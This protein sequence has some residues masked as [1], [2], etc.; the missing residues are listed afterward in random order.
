[1]ETSRKR[2]SDPNATTSPRGL[3]LEEPPG[4]LAMLRDF[5]PGSMLPRPPAKVCCG[6]LEIDRIE[7][8]AVL[9]GRALRLTGREFA[10]LLCLA[11]HGNRVV[12]R[13]VLLAT[14]WSS[15]NAHGFDVISVYP[16]SKVVDVYVKRLR[17]KFEG[18]ARRIETV[19]GFGYCLRPS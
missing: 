15:T 11:D 2:V 5:N 16:W 9:A 17:E 3:L 7:R 13:S 1:M 12:S 4:A 10:L 19:R 18:R 6:D 8:R 14:V